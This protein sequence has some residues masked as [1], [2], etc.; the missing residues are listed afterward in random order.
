MVIKGLAGIAVLILLSLVVE[1]GDLV[2]LLD[3]KNTERWLL[4]ARWH[5]PRVVRSPD[6]HGRRPQPHSPASP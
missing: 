2:Q 6:G 3:P 4:E 5:G 1:I